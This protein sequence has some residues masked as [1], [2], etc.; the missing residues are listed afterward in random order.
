MLFIEKTTSIA[1]LLKVTMVEFY[2]IANIT[3][4]IDMQ[5][6]LMLSHFIPTGLLSILLQIDFSIFVRVV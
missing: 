5:E 6:L 2:S 1:I 3:V 4:N